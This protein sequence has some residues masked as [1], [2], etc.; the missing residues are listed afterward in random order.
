MLKVLNMPNRLFAFSV[1]LVSVFALAA[2]PEP[3][4]AGRTT[5]NVF[6]SSFFHF[7][8]E[9]PKGWSAL[10]DDVRLAEN[11]KRYKDALNEAIGHNDQSAPEN[12]NL[13]TEAI[14]PY[15]LLLAARTAVASGD[16]RPLPRVLI[17][18]SMRRT[19]M[20]EA[21]DPAKIII[22]MAHPKVL[23]DSEEVVLSGHKF[24]RTDFQMKAASFLSKFATV[25]GDYIIEFD[26]RADNEKDL[27]DLVNTMQTLKFS[28]H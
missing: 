19:M 11:Q 25:N 28:D 21:G 1:L 3:I 22:Q 23:R 16:A 17:Q 18:A 14:V 20:A 27:A 12:Q 15:N 13:I 8:Y 26:L 4:D 24:V 10:A 6:E 5:A 7:R 9:L 2:P